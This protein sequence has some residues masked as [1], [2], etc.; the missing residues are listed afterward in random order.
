[1]KKVNILFFLIVF[2]AIFLR[3]YK[4]S[5]FAPGLY[6]DETSYGY[7]AYSLIKTGH[8]EFG[9]FWPM[10]FKSF[11]DYKPPMSAWLT[12]PSILAFGLNEF[13][14]RFPAAVAGTLTVVI[15]YFLTKEIFIVDNKEFKFKEIKYLPYIASALIA[16]SPWHLLFSR[17]SMLVGFEIMFTSAGLLFFLKSLKKTKFLYLS[18]VCFDFSIYSYY[19]ARVTIVLLGLAILGIFKKDLLRIRK[20]LIGV[21]LLGLLV[22][23]PLIFSIYKDPLTLTGRA[24]TVSIFFDPGIKLKLWQAHTLDGTDYPVLL[25]RFYHNKFYFYFIDAARR[26]LQHFSFDFLF[27]SG[28]SHPPFFIP[29]MGVAYIADLAF[30]LYGLFLAF[31]NRSKKLNLLLAYFFISPIVASFTFLTPSTNR[32]FNMVIG[33]TIFTGLGVVGVL[34]LLIEN[35]SMFRVGIVIIASI[36]LV[37]LFYYLNIY[38]VIIPKEAAIEWHFGRRE[39][40]EK[41]SKYENNY[42]EVVI[43][44][45]QGPAYIWL[46][47]YKKYD[48][49]KYW[50]TAQVDN[51]PDELGWIKV[52]GFDK[53]KII[54]PFEWNNIE[55]KTNDLYVSFEDDIPTGWKGMING[56]EYE[57]VDVDKVIYPAGGDAFKLLKLQ[58]I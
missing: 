37:S 36:Y 20:T 45:T 50:Q 18:V 1:M 12:I 41:I 8:D 22:L 26:Y 57:T 31:R 44:G 56:S 23:S 2:L 6:S 58:K 35:F 47:F 29:R 5:E 49:F 38:Y 13:A 39:L 43:S 15:V 53:Y 28:D 25:S 46:L 27:L 42:D 33:W 10:S 48:P 54:R 30:F 52:D 7:N 16:I 14:V 3:F 40:V 32:S 4:L 19:G 24:K 34:N 51:V 55:K 17:S 11:G 21:I 9:K